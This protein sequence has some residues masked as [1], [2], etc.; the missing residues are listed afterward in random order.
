MKAVGPFKYYVLCF[1]LALPCGHLL[2]SKRSQKRFPTLSM[3][4]VRVHTEVLTNKLSQCVSIARH[5]LEPVRFG[6]VTT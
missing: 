6:E 5:T 1:W 3:L 4:A 2:A